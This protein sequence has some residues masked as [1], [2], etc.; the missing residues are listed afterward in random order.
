[1]SD[2]IIKDVELEADE[3]IEKITDEKYIEEQARLEKE[4]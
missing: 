2:K 1:M 3:E 4:R